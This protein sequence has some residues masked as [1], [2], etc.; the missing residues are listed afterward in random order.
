MTINLFKFFRTS[1]VAVIAI[2][3]APRLKHAIYI[4]SVTGKIYEGH[5]R[6][7]TDTHLIFPY[8]THVNKQHDTIYLNTSF[9]SKGSLPVAKIRI[10][11][12]GVQ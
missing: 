7:I 11:L 10:M 3:R 12:C 4:C 8:Y 6:P 2:K 1:K 5:Y 9:S